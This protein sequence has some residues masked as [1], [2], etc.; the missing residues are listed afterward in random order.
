VLLVLLFAAVVPA[1]C[2]LW[3]MNAAMRNERL[4]VRQRLADVYRQKVQ[5]DREEIAAFWSSRLQLPPAILRHER[6]MQPWALLLFHR[7][8][9]DGKSDSAILLDNAGLPVY[10]QSVA[11][12]PTPDSLPDSPAWREARRLEFELADYERGAAAYAHAAEEARSGKPSRRPRSQ[13]LLAQARC[14]AKAG[15]LENALDVLLEEM[16]ADVHLQVA[17]D[18]HGRAVFLDAQMLALQLL[19]ANDA[20]RVPLARVLAKQVN[21]YGGTPV[22]L[23]SPIPGVDIPVDRQL[24]GEAVMTSSQRLL[25]MELLNAMGLEG[26]SFPTQQAEALAQQYLAD[27]TVEPKPGEVTPTGAPR[28]WQMASSDGH[29]I[30]LFGEEN[31]LADLSAAA[32]LDEPFAGITTRIEPPGE[33]STGE[34]PFLSVPVS[35]HFPDWRLAVYLDEDPFAVSAGQ[36]ELTYLIVGVSAIAAIAVLAVAMAS[37]LG[38]QIKLTRLKNDL[39]ATVSHELKTPLASMRVLVDTLREGR[40]SGQRQTS[41]YLALIAK[42]NERLSRLIDNFL[43]FSRMERNKRAFEFETFDLR[44]AVRTA[45]GSVGERFAPPQTRLDVNLPDQPL[46]IRAD[47]DATVTVILNLL[48]NAWKYSGQEK[49]I[50]VQ[51]RRRDGE[52]SIEVSDNGVGLSRRAMRRIFDRF[53]QVDQTL[54]RE[55]GGCGLGLSIVQFI[56]DA[57]GGTIDVHSELGKG[58]TFIVALP[59][60]VADSEETG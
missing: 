56:L 34:K 52:V 53:Y 24:V 48:D 42:E 19:P 38:R 39:I 36:A 27:A 59:A 30:S 51:A 22:T 44:E 41:E 26:V 31:L 45:A 23:K 28:V 9:G 11:A 47:R 8:V 17:R 43:T 13:A 40:S 5:T 49:R 1:A 33:S 20:R 12:G 4:A 46:P 18:E 29:V 25:F 35:E 50:R 54:A 60:A 57:H 6:A 3:F 14:L 55:A 7:M 2:V 16:S 37:Y 21:N 10:P 32:R 15:K 58:S